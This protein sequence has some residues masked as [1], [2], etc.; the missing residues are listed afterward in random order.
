RQRLEP[1]RFEER[2]RP[3]P[4]RARH[5]Y[6]HTGEAVVVTPRLALRGLVLDAEVAAAR[7]LAGE[8]VAAHQLA[9]LEEIGHAAGALQLL[10]QLARAA[11]HGHV[12]P[13][14]LTQRRDLV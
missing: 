11:G 8:G 3:A 7:L 4:G 2:L 6:R 10:V 12:V 13:E 14:R 9:Q 5:P 1:Q